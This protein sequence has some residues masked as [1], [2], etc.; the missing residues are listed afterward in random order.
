M[1]K[2]ES[3]LLEEAITTRHTNYLDYLREYFIWLS[4][5]KKVSDLRKST[6]VEKIDSDAYHCYRIV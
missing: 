3:Q 1:K 2:L 4:D 6:I 5:N